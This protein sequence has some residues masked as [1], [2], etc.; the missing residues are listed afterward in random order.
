MLQST[1][2]RLSWMN[3]SKHESPSMCTSPDGPTDLMVRVVPTAYRQ[4]NA[5][6]LGAMIKGEHSSSA[7]L[8]YD[9][10]TALRDFQR[11]SHQILGR[12]MA[13]EIVHIL[14]PVNSHAGQGLM[15]ATWKVQVQCYNPACLGLSDR[16]ILMVQAEARRRMAA[17]SSVQDDQTGKELPLSEPCY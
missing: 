6:A 16:W 15:R 14:L 7:V 13:H 11:A 9:R 8:F 3:C 1:H 4:A 12:A 5:K 10:V 17:A 2:L